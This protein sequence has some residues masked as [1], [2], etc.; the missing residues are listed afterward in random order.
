MRS[1]T[2]AMAGQ[3]APINCGYGVGYSVLDI[4]K[5]V[6]KAA[7]SPLNK[8]MAPRRAGDPAAIVAGSDK[9][10]AE[11]GWK[12]EHQDLDRI[13]AKRAR[14]GGLLAPAE[15]GRLKGAAFGGFAAPPILRSSGGESIAPTLADDDGPKWRSSIPWSLC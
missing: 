7:G 13:V 2:C 14:L 12:P 4:I 6:E 9:I 11:L 10:K 8:R 15:R 1:S 3:A 5:A